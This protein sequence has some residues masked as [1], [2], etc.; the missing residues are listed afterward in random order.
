MTVVHKML[1]LIVLSDVTSLWNFFQKLNY[2][3]CCINSKGKV[4]DETT[5]GAQWFWSYFLKWDDLMLSPFINTDHFFPF[6]TIELSRCL[7]A[8]VANKWGAA[9]VTAW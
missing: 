4:S 1:V 9:F 7:H 6:L 3:Q 5:K 8:D 2:S